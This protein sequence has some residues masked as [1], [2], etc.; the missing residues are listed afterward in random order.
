MIA[1]PH[2]IELLLA[3]LGADA[4]LRDAVIGDLAE[5]FADRVKRDGVGAARRWYYREAMRATPHLAYNSVCRLSV[6]GLW[7]RLGIAA[8]AYTIMLITSLV[9]LAIL[10][11]VAAAMGTRIAWNH[12][13]ESTSMIIALLA[14]DVAMALF[15]GYVA[16][17]LDGDTPLVGA[18]ML[19]LVWIIAVFAAGSA[20]RTFSHLTPPA[21]VL[22]FWYRSIATALIPIGTVAGGALRVGTRGARGAE[23]SIAGL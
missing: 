3:S 22:P 10:N 9:P 23:N 4:D 1:P 16:A 12:I 14:A 2:T 21:S 19:G 11:S 18:G 17:Y 13:P 8:T 6:K 20:I 7:H 15:G 5:D